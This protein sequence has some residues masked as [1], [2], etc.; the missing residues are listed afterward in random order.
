MSKA[1][2]TARVVAVVLLVVG[3]VLIV[4]SVPDA[5]RYVKIRRM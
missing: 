2:F 5:N 3:V 4:R 1:G